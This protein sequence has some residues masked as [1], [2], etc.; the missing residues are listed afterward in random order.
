MANQLSVSISGSG[1]TGAVTLGLILLDAVAKAGF[2][3]K[4]ARAFGPQ[5][6]G[7]ESAV[8]LHFADHPIET[9]ADYSQLHCALDWKNFERFHDEIPLTEHSLVLY[10]NS[11]EK[12]PEN[13]KQ[14]GARIEGYPFQ[15]TLK[16]LKGSRVNMIALGAVA[17]CLGLAP[18]TI[19]QALQKTLG[20]KGQ[21]AVDLSL[22]SV[23]LGQEMVAEPQF[24]FNGWQA[25]SRPRWNISGNE[26]CGL[27]ALHAGLKF[28]AAY[29]IT[30][31]T[32]I[33]EY[34]APRLE[35][36]GGSLL[37]A[38]DELAAIN[39]AI[40][41]SFGG[42]PS[43]TAT[44]GPGFALMTEAMGLA[45]A[46][47][48]P[49]LV[50]T[51]MRGGP[52]TGIPTK[53]EQTDLN[54]VLYGFHGEAPH[55]VI[56][57]LNVQESSHIT[58]WALALAEHLQ[59][60]AVLVSDQNIG[61]SRVIID[62]IEPL[63]LKAEGLSRTLVSPQDDADSYQRYA[64]TQNGISP[65]SIPGMPD[66]QY[67]ADGLEHAPSGTPSSSAED[68]LAQLR[69]RAEKLRQ[70]DFGARWAHQLKVASPQATLITW[71]SS[72]EAVQSAVQQLNAAGYR[73]QL[74]GLRLLLPLPVAS[75]KK[76]L[77]GKICVIEQN[78][79]AQLYHHLLGEKAIPKSSLSLAHPGPVL[80]KP[81]DII[82]QLTPWLEAST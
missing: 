68:H 52:S 32:D 21:E 44:S 81:S 1:G 8:I 58:Q 6:R 48:T 60:L 76:A 40:G 49:V 82:A 14:T 29:P 3:G 72:F 79:S 17:K 74:I 61:Q 35:K 46:S 4:M 13:V 2:Y 63:D 57:P 77:K 39:M 71:G 19:Q 62:P 50:V 36:R 31:A 5:I 41:A 51:V 55:L 70:F 59:T 11:R 66:M 80:F 64:L 42:A 43:M 67:T 15:N 54:Q 38:E 20:R 75:V 23:Q 25:Q 65:M 10:D 69:K 22:A 24:D 47:E 53:S 28:A 34:L 27:G 12:L 26:A 18:E 45:I 78:A 33:V 73:L 30:P 16:Q 7:G 37:I 56:A 9:S